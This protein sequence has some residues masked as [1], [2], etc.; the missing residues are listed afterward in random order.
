MKWVIA[1]AVGI[2][3]LFVVIGCILDIEPL[4]V[5]LGFAACSG[6]LFFGFFGSHDNVG[7]GN[8]SSAI[9][10]TRMMEIQIMLINL[11]H[12][13]IITS[14]EMKPSRSKWTWLKPL[15]QTV[16]VEMAYTNGIHRTV[17][18]KKN[19]LTYLYQFIV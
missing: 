16:S 10:L 15:N 6:I 8:S 19:E 5:M 7:F 3:M 18:F 17:D 14:D 13:R 12:A 1:T 9:S 2:C 11:E 4:G